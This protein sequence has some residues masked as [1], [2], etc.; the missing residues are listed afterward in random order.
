MSSHTLRMH[1][2]LRAPPEQV[3]RAFLHPEALAKWL[4]PHGYTCQVHEM[5]VRVGGRYRMSFTQFSTGHRQALAGT[6]LELIPGERIVQTAR[7]EAAHLS[8][9]IRTAI[10]LN[11]LSRGTELQIMQDGIPAVIPP[12]DCC[13]AWQESLLLLAQ[14]LEVRPAA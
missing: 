11:A 10:R 7:F 8:G 6:Y 9:E 1:R 4:P 12:D 5:E 2:M 13:L 14:L 3:Y